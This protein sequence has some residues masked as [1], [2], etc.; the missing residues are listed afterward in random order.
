MVKLSRTTLG[1]LDGVIFSGLAAAV[2]FLVGAFT[3]VFVE[4]FALDD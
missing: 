4:R 1:D 2:G 3:T